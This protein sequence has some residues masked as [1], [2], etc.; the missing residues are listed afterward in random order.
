[1]IVEDIEKIKK[2][3]KE[4]LGAHHEFKFPLETSEDPEPLK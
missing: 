2:I 1:M 3:I 4:E